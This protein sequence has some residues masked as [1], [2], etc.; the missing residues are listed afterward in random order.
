[1]A[2]WQNQW[3]GDRGQALVSTELT[4]A[5]FLVGSFTP[6]AG[7]DLWAEVEG[8][9]ATAQ[10]EVPLR[11]LVQVKATENEKTESVLDV[12]VDQI[13]RWA[14]QPLPMFLIGVN[15]ATKRF[16][17]KSIDEIVSDDLAGRNPFDVSA[18]TAR[19][20][21]TFADNISVVLKAATTR[22]Y[23]VFQLDLADVPDSQIQGH[24]F[25]I[26]RRVNPQP[27]DRVPILRWTVLWKSS[28]RPQHFAAMLAELTRRAKREG[29]RAEPQPML[30]RFEI[31]RSSEDRHNNVAAARVLVVNPDHPRAQ[32]LRTIL[33]CPNGYSVSRDRDV[34]ETR[35]YYQSITMA[36]EEFR[37]YAANVGRALDALTDKVLARAKAGARVWDDALAA[38][39]EAVVA[40]WNNM[41]V[42]PAECRTLEAILDDHFQQLLEHKLIGRNRAGRFS[43]TAVV[44]ELR[45]REVKLGQCRGAWAAVLRA[46]R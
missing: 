14:A 24:Y 1:M 13:R 26:L 4:S 6:D 46:E 42:A 5:G 18:K 23:E 29:E 39:F 3:T 45:D 27:A 37:T 19:V 21:L 12:E 36:P 31:F 34:E 41:T 38:E 28:P 40:L 16:F 9:R 2:G 8:R 17:V 33:N 7:E 15:V 22:H 32:H 44:L 30:F 43:A 25:E 35:E 20:K 10:G 11:A